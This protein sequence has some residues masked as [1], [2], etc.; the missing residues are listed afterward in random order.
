M[1]SGAH[2]YS[3]EI[4]LGERNFNYMRN[5]VK[6]TVDAYDGETNLYIFDENDVLIQAYSRLFPGLFKPS[7]A[8]PADLRGAHALP[9]DALPRPGR[10]LSHVPHARPGG[11]L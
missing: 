8:M 11:F 3:R 5:S 2:P 4:T 9:R 6:A 10:D 1:S 7:S